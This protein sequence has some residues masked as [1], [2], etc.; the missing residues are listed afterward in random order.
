MLQTAAGHMLRFRQPVA[1][2][3]AWVVLGE[4]S[5]VVGLES[6]QV[7]EGPLWGPIPLWEG[8]CPPQ[9]CCAAQFFLQGGPVL[10]AA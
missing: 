1:E 8:G 5:S 9:R 7:V 3:P 6:Q 10:P 4:K 2:G